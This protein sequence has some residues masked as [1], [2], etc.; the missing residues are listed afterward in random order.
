MQNRMGQVLYGRADAIKDGMKRVP[1]RARLLGG[2]AAAWRAD[3]EVCDKKDLPRLWAKKQYYLAVLLGQ[4]AAVSDGEDRARLFGESVAATRAALEIFNISDFPKQWAVLQAFLENV[5]CL[6]ALAS[7]GAERER[8][9]GEAVTACREELK[10]LAGPSDRA[11]AQNFLGNALD[12]QAMA[13]E[14]PDRIRLLNEA[15]GYYEA[16]LEFYT[17]DAY[18][19]D[20][21]KT[22][23]NLSLARRHLAEA[24]RG[25]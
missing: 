10:A 1:E 15:I 8:L 3:L 24:T 18:P 6:Q 16:A 22:Q 25:N 14:G 13:T 9:F 11:I 12:Y 23:N 17:E 19:N 20:R 2:T 4:Q 21:K 7:K 5:L